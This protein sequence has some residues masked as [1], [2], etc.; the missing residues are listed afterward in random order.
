MI[1][2]VICPENTTNLQGYIR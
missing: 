2:E 1:T